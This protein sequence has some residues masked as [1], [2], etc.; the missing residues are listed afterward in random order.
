MRDVYIAHTRTHT[1]IFYR[2]MSE[3]E[4]KRA[5]ARAFRYRRRVR[6]NT[7]IMASSP[8]D[9][10]VCSLICLSVATVVLFLAS[11][12][13]LVLAVLD[14]VRLGTGTMFAKENDDDDDD[15]DTQTRKTKPTT[16]TKP[17]P[18]YG[19]TFLISFIAFVS[20]FVMLFGHGHAKIH[21]TEGSGAFS[22]SSSSL[23]P[24]S[25]SHV[26]A[27]ARYV[28]WL[29]TTPLLLLDLLW[30][31][32]RGRAYDVASVMVLDVLMIVLGCVAAFVM[33]SWPRY[34]LWALS[35]LAM[36]GIFAYLLW[37]MKVA[38][39]Q[40]GR[41]GQGQRERER[42]ARRYKK[43]MYWILVLWSA[44]PVVWLASKDGVGA[45][46][47]CT[48]VCSYA[49]LDVMAKVGFGMFL[50]LHK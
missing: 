3:G 43:G 7:N 2:G 30:V 6:M 12:A 1:H 38:E 9:H 46:S 18:R 45:I 16:Q 26:T 5:V 27:W 21:R 37:F 49:F 22:L 36:L 24:P 19:I 42:E 15:D 14:R 20:Y 50:L 23:S 17:D 47:T 48:E 13:F 28:D 11:V 33:L 31:V 41:P 32:G 44:Y 34:V 8:H 25:S 35:T 29:A 39:S 40:E 4:R 10:S